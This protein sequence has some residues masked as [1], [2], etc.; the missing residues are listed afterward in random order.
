MINKQTRARRNLLTLLPGGVT[1][2]GLAARRVR[3]L[4]RARALA[5]VVGMPEGDLDA[6]VV[7]LDEGRAAIIDRLATLSIDYNDSLIVVHLDRELSAA[8]SYARLIDALVE[9]LDASVIVIGAAEERSLMDALFGQLSPPARQ[10]TFSLVGQS[11]LPLLCGLVETADLVIAADIDLARLAT[12]L[13]T[14][15][16]ALAMPAKSGFSPDDVARMA[17]DLLAA[18]EQPVPSLIT[19]HARALPT[20]IG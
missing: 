19:Q 10:A 20:S 5:D 18:V 4:A 6:V 11:A 16:V 3:D 14:P 2:D 1:A 7:L 13:D 15:L 17:G 12:A 8:T 9:R